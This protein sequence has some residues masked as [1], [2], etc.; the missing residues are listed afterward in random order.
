[1]WIF[2]KT[3]V[4]PRETVCKIR[5]GS[6]AESHEAVKRAEKRPHCHFA[7]PKTRDLNAQSYFLGVQ[8]RNRASLPGFVGSQGL[9]SGPREIFHTV[10]ERLYENAS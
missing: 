9:S 7:P 4:N 8:P 5:I 1:M 10:S 3:K 2:L 6:T